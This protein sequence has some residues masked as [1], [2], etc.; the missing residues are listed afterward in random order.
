MKGGLQFSSGVNLKTR[1]CYEFEKGTTLH[2][3]Y[4]ALC[5][6]KK[7]A[8]S[9]LCHGRGSGRDILIILRRSILTLKDR[10]GGIYQSDVAER[11]RKIA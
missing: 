1:A 9:L 2:G 5:P 6:S 10:P 11:L 3:Q 8:R 4:S 7:S